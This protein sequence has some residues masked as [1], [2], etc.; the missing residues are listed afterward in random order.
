MNKDYKL[1]ALIPVAC[2]MASAILL[3]ACAGRGGGS[4]DHAAEGTHLR[5]RRLVL[6]MLRKSRVQHLADRRARWTPRPTWA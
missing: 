5:Q 4:S 6:R 1:H 2:S 3:S